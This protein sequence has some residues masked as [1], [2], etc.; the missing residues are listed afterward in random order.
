MGL[1]ANSQS[2]VGEMVAGKHSITNPIVSV[3]YSAC[4][5]DRFPLLTHWFFDNPVVVWGVIRVHWL[6]EGP[7][8]FMCLQKRE[9]PK[10][11]HKEKEETLEKAET[12]EE[13][14]TAP[15]KWHL[16]QVGQHRCSL[17]FSSP[18]FS[19]LLS[20]IYRLPYSGGEN[21]RSRGRRRWRKEKGN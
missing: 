12:N 16:E 10:G 19:L 13:Q 17:L 20:H 5:A 4:Y 11:R 8:H 7:R 18:L 3:H 1:G 15:W 6:Q 21:E 14:Q 2:M 9:G